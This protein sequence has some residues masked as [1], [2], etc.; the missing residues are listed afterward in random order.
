MSRKVA[1]AGLFVTALA[2]LSRTT[3]TPSSVFRTAVN[4]IIKN[5]VANTVS[6]K[7]GKTEKIK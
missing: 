2:Q 7:L 5:P 4:E 1:L 6:V 3:G